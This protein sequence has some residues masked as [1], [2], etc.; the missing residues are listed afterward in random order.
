ML[1]GRAQRL[2]IVGLAFALGAGARAESRG[3]VRLFPRVRVD[4]ASMTLADLLPAAAPD[5]MRER[6]ARILLGAAPLAGSPR[7]FSRAEI[8][9]RLDSRLARELEIPASVVVER[10][11]R[12][13]SREEVLAAIRAALGEKGFQN[14]GALGLEDVSVGMPVM[15]TTAEPGLRVLGMKL[16]PVLHLAVFRLWTAKEQAVRPFGVMGQAGD[17]LCLLE[18]RKVKQQRLRSAHGEGGNHDRAAALDGLVDDV[19]E[20]VRDRAVGMLAI[21]V[22]RFAEQK[23]GACGRLRI[24]QDR[25]IVA[26]QVAREDHDRLLSVLRNRQLEPR[27]AENMACVVRANGKLRPNRER[28]CARNLAELRES[29]VRFL[30]RIEGQRRFVPRVALSCSVARIFFLQVFRDG[31]FHAD[32]HQGNLFVDAAGKLVAV[33]FGLQGRLRRPER[34]GLAESPLG[35]TTRAP[36][37]VPPARLVTAL[38][39]ERGVAPATREGLL[40]LYPERDVAPARPAAGGSRRPL[41]LTPPPARLLS[42]GGGRERPGAGP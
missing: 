27:R 30:H 42:P 20:F 17:G 35:F 23:I 26:A 14:A 12:E 8:E 40:S 24:F 7:R 39:T 19:R 3:R 5:G 28:A 9:S 6:A 37:P 25:L 1:P 33:D 13:L 41:R 2:L 31:F 11:A 22:G 21:S 15:V 36:P 38:I 34:R 29:G 10:R 16:D 4:S 32:M 18:L